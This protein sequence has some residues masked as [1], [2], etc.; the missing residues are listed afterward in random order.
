MQPAS[1]HLADRFELIRLTE[2]LKKKAEEDRLYQNLIHRA[3]NKDPIA[4]FKLFQLSV[5]D[6]YTSPN[7][8]TYPNSDTFKYLHQAVEAGHAGAKIIKKF[9]EIQGDVAIYNPGIRAL[10]TH[11]DPYGL[12]TWITRSS[13]KTLTPARPPCNKGKHDT[14][15]QSRES[16]SVLRSGNQVVGNAQKKEASRLQTDQTGE[17]AA[18]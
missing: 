11:T 13:L 4:L 18:Q 8:D 2:E 10:I 7:S 12:P 1:A 14:L 15:L 3:Q 5:K 6:G 17:K 9:L 16:R